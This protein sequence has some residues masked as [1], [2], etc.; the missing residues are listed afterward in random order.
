MILSFVIREQNG[1]ISWT[2]RWVGQ[3]L[4]AVERGVCQLIL[5]VLVKWTSPSFID[6]IEGGNLLM[7]DIND[8]PK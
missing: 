3:N 7:G 6:I 1:G 8:Y 5:N 2:E 4:D